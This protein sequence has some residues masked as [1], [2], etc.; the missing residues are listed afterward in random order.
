MLVIELM[1]RFSI[2]F[3]L[4]FSSI[5][6]QRFPDA[7]VDSLLINGINEILK[8]DYNSAD[9]IFLSLDKKYPELPFGK[10]FL[11][12]T[13]ISM[14]NDYN[15]E[16]NED[17]LDDLFEEAEEIIE[18]YKDINGENLWYNYFVALVNG[19]KS[20]YSIE[21]GDFLTG[22]LNGIESIKSF[23]NCLDIDK[24]FAESFVSIG[25][26]LYWK[27]KKTEII[28][29]FPF[30]EDNS[31][32]GILF[33]ERAVKETIYSRKLAV[34]S[35]IWIYINEKRYDDA[36]AISKIILDQFPNNRFVK[37][38]LASAYYYLNKEK[39][40]ETLAEIKNSLINDKVLNDRNKIILNY[41]IAKLYFEINKNE[42]AQ[43]I[44]NE[45]IKEFSTKENIDSLVEK[46]LE[47]TY[48]LMDQFKAN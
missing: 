34:Y 35:L 29:W 14:A 36:V 31:S 26:Y 43:K 13:K 38:A 30:V 48:E 33:L 15:I 44:C 24:K 5:F 39:S 6:G 41:R 40:I 10:L 23:E 28:D 8:E 2:V 1:A 45:I 25:N 46:R 4:L 17:D 12:L 27:S 11:A 18:N 22:M 16:I 21:Q 9:K 19:Y 7:K 47:M 20:Y 3:I 42:K 37:R 32:Q